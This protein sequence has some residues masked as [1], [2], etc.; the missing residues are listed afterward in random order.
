MH[1]MDQ[2]VRL[3][4]AGNRFRKTPIVDDDFPAIRDSF[5]QELLTA[6]N[7]THQTHPHIVTLCGSTRFKDAFQKANLEETL[8]GHIVLSVGCYTH[9]DK[10]LG[11]TGEEKKFLDELHLQK[12]RLSDSVLILNVGGYI[13]EST[14]RELDFAAAQGKILRFLEPQ[15]RGNA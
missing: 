7:F 10:D 1:V 3:V 11:I 14:R 8:K 13:G 5:D 4:K 12:I 9:A 6:T 2:L 15:G